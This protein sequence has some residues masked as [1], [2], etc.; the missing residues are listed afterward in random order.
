M[1]DL[2]APSLPNRLQYT[3]SDS[4]RHKAA[5]TLDSEGRASILN[6]IMIDCWQCD[7]KRQ[8][9]THL[10]K[11]YRLADELAAKRGRDPG[12]EPA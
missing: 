9:V 8:G 1:H 4:G 12:D 6:R 2:V 7:P 3:C 11:P 5:S 10:S